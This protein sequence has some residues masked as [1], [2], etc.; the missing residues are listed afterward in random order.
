[1]G[2]RLTWMGIGAAAGFLGAAYSYGRLR[3]SAKQLGPEQVADAVVLVVDEV[4]DRVGGF[5]S[6]VRREA[7]EVEREIRTARALRLPQGRP[8]LPAGDT[9]RPMALP[10]GERG[11]TR[12]LELPAASTELH[13]RSPRRRVRSVRG[14][15]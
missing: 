5:A 11:V 3:A 7:D 8:A 13:G 6:E 1:M 15:R 9:T 14:G 2:R 4:A 10:R 12:A